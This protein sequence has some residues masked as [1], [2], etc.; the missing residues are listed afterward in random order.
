MLTP[1]LC[2]VIFST[3][4]LDLKTRNWNFPEN[5]CNIFLEISDFPETET[6]SNDSKSFQMSQGYIKNP[7]VSSNRPCG[8]SA[9]FLVAPK[10]NA[11]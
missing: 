11:I 3:S 9:V 8:C 5:S 2:I 6:F 10:M 1:K 4:S 7:K